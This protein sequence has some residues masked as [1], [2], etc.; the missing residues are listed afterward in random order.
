MHEIYLSYD[1]VHGY[2]Q[3]TKSFAQLRP[4][5]PLRVVHNQIGSGLS[6]RCS[7]A[8]ILEP[9]IVSAIGAHL[10]RMLT[11]FLWVIVH[12]NMHGRRTP[13]RM[14]QSVCINVLGL[15]LCCT[16]AESRLFGMEMLSVD[17]DLRGGNR[18]IGGLESPPWGQRAMR[19]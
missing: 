19:C 18:R 12:L 4:T 6:S 3:K 17:G 16:S 7:M 2:L 10:R 5:S 11:F 9:S 13:V 1:S 14:S 15:V 8:C